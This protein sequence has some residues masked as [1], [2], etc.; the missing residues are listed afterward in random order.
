MNY[1]TR[2]F[3][4]NCSLCELFH[5]INYLICNHI[6]IRYRNVWHSFSNCKLENWKKREKWKLEI[7]LKK[8]CSVLGRRK[9]PF[10]PVQ[11]KSFQSSLCNFNSSAKSLC[12]DST[13]SIG[14]RSLFIYLFWYSFLTLPR[15]MRVI[16]NPNYSHQ[17]SVCIFT[18]RHFQVFEFMNKSE[19][20]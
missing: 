19:T 18:P 13:C 8:K 11:C 2:S 12:H 20:I 10:H 5:L 6:L 3:R 16:D 9:K 14:T 17:P 4:K 1:S 15:T 7:N